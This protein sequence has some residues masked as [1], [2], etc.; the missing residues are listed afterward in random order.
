MLLI[1]QISMAVAL[2]A[3]LAAFV[4]LLAGHFA[5]R[6]GDSANKSGYLMTLVGF[7]GFT[8]ATFVLG[9]AFFAENYSIYYVAMNRSTDVSALW[10]LYK[11]SGVWAGREGSLLFWTWLMSA[12]SA[13]VV[14]KAISDRDRNTNVA[15]IVMNFIIAV[16]TVSMVFALQNNPFVATPDMYLSAGQLVGSAANWGMNPLLQHWAMILHPPTLFIGYAGLAVPF[17]YAIAALVNRDPSPDWVE[18]S[19]RITMFS[20]LFL[21]AGIGLG[22][23]WAYVVLGWGG[24]WAWDPVENAS[25]LSWFAGVGLIHSFT[26]YR[27]RDGFKRWAI[28]LAALTFAMVILGTFITRSGIVQSVHAFAPDNLSFW[29]FLTLIMGSLALAGGL[30]LSRWSMFQGNDDFES[31]TGREAAYYFN[32]VL[33]TVASLLI[34][35]MTVSSALPTWMPFG[36][37]ALGPI[38]YELVARPV[39]ILYMMILAVCPILMWNKTDGAAMWSKVKWPM[40]WALGIFA[41]LMVEWW[42]VLRPVWFDMVAQGGEVA[43]EFEAFGPV[44]IYDILAIAALLVSSFVIT[45][46]A[47]LFVRGTRAR[48]KAMGENVAQAFFSVLTKARTQS[49]GYLSHI[50][51]GLIVIGLV[52]SSMYVRDSTFVIPNTPGE[53]F[54]ISDYSFEYM[55]IE[56]ERLSNGDVWTYARL[57]VSRDGKLLGEVDPSMTQF[58]VQDQTRLNAV[59]LPEPLRDIFVVFQGLVENSISINVKINPLI[60][61]M[62]GGFGLL[63]VGTALASWPRRRATAG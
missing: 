48:M 17:A 24:F 44:V 38:A 58:A 15:L 23:A 42:I 11:L 60:W 22:S 30:L 34:A 1:G 10:W 37:Q 28:M 56:Q 27:R 21:G 31:L 25:V 5:G 43:R 29:L 61:F 6:K 32:N 52:G 63:L 54:Q 40:V 3:T 16:F 7:G 13:F 19:D 4:M 45:T 57:N 18:K 47:A 59:V 26:L 14:W 53:T 49:G 62:W 20:W 55:G 50:A 12:F 33:M 8:L 51:M 35:Y 41:A 39:G 2:L 9:A 36:G 46:N